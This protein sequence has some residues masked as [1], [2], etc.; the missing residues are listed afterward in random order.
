MNIASRS[1]MSISGSTSSPCIRNG[2]PIFSMRSSTRMI[3][4]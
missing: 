3:F 4:L 1:K 2:M